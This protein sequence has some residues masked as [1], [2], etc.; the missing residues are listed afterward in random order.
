[1]KEP[2]WSL[3]GSGP[4][5]LGR[6]RIQVGWLPRSLTKTVLK[7]RSGHLCLRRLKVST[8]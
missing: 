5:Q 6:K 4:G 7:G 1:M 3:K 8:G 2:E